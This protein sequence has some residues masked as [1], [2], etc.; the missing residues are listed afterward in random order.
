MKSKQKIRTV[1]RKYQRL[2][3]AQPGILG[4]GAGLVDDSRV[5]GHSY[6]RIGNNPAI[7]V[8]NKRCASLNDLKVW[9]GYDPLEPETLQILSVRS[10]QRYGQGGLDVSPQ[11]G[12]HAQ[13]HGWFER[14]TV[15]VDLRQ[16]MPFRPRVDG[17]MTLH[18]N[19]GITFLGGQWQALVPADIDMSSHIPI[20]G[21]SYSLVY[22]DAAGTLQV[23]TGATKDLNTLYPSDAPAP[24]VGTVPVALLRLYSGMSGIIENRI[25]TDLGDPRWMGLYGGT[26]GGGGSSG[27]SYSSGTIYNPSNTVSDETTWGIAPNAGASIEYSRGDHTHGMPLLPTIGNIGYSDTSVHNPPYQEDIIN[28]FGDV[29]TVGSGVLGLINGDGNDTDVYLVGSTATYWWYQA[30]AKAPLAPA[31]YGDLTFIA[32]DTFTDTDGTSL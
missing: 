3:N 31:G 25:A 26:G 20:T 2:P 28:A 5:P 23:D 19:R 11:V 10:Y 16:M 13:T 8:V 1:L 12:S 6:V 21:S 30:L 29:S 18:V 4:N 27:T 14:D 9:V 22:Y 32:L 7:S 24:I 15:F 17:S